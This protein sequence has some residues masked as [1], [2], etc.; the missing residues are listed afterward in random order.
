MGTGF[1][2][3]CSAVIVGSLHAAVPGELGLRSVQSRGHRV[4]WRVQCRG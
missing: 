3:G 1:T 4:Y 2:G